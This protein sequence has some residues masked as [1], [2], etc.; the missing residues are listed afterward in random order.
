MLQTHI[1]VFQRIVPD[2]S[3]I[4]IPW[5]FCWKSLWAFGFVASSE[6]KSSLLLLP[7]TA[8]K[9]LAQKVGT[10]PSVA[11]QRSAWAAKLL[12][13]TKYIS[14]GRVS[15]LIRHLFARITRAIYP[16]INSSTTVKL[17]VISLWS[18]SRYA[19]IKPWQAA[20]PFLKSSDG[21]P[22]GTL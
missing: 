22:S 21:K 4:R 2:T 15:M 1:P 5:A 11:A 19:W 12:Q 10:S 17:V 16:E 8:L 18:T 20:L 14:L 6:G 9:Q 3:N 13:G 7:W